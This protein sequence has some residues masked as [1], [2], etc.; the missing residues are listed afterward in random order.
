MYFIIDPR[1]TVNKELF[2]NLIIENIV[3]LIKLI[4]SKSNGIN[5]II[6]PSQPFF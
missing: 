1:K 4:V 5:K 3:C 2:K 6:F